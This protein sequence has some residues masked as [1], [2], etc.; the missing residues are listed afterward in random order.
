MLLWFNVSFGLQDNFALID[1]MYRYQHQ[2][3]YA[4]IELHAENDWIDIYGIY[5]NEM[6]K[7][8][9]IYFSPALDSYTLG[10]VIDLEFASVTIEHQCVHPVNPFNSVVNT[11]DS[12]YNKICI[13]LGTKP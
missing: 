1:N 7:S 5:K 3:I 2:P 11:I 8:D 12:G 10:A 13:T 4:E 6:S 9:S